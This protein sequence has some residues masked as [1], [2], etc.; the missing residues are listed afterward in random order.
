V[1]GWVGGWMDRW[2]NEWMDGWMDK[3]M[4]GWMDGRK[5]CESSGAF[6]LHQENNRT[7]AAGLIAF[8]KQELTKC[9]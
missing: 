3:W 7:F 6:L 5:R 4:D 9:L 8:C 2:I 1:G